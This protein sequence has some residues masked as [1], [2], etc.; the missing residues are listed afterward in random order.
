MAGVA[1]ESNAEQLDKP[2]GQWLL[3]VSTSNVDLLHLK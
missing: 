3:D 2:A 1:D